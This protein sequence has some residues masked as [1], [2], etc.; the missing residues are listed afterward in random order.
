MTTTG[1]RSKAATIP[2]TAS[3]GGASALAVID[4]A[5]ATRSHAA[6]SRRESTTARLRHRPPLAA[7]RQPRDR[8]LGADPRHR[9]LRDDA[10]V[11]LDDDR[12]EEGAPLPEVRALRLAVRQLVR[13]PD[14]RAEAHD[15]AALL[16]RLPDR[17]Q[18]RRLVALLPSAREKCPAPGLENDDVSGLVREHD[19][20]AAAQAVL[21]ARQARP[22][23][24]D[25]G[26]GVS[27]GS[28][29]CRTIPFPSRTSK[30]NRKSRNTFFEDSPSRIR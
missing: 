9:V 14:A 1:C 23:F 29:D 7:V 11:A 12:R 24:R 25:R 10:G 5:I 27:S 30:M 6:P 2:F 13:D 18:F 15:E 4:A 28:V 20:A 17:G 16:D 22:E 8:L 21:D 26:H 3:T 19:V